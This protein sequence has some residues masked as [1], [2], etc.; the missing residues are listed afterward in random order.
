MFH[1]H[2]SIIANFLSLFQLI[3]C[4]ETRQCDN[5]TRW[6][7]FSGFL[8]ILFVRQSLMRV[9]ATTIGVRKKEGNKIEQ[10][11]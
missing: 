5:E 6:N 11:M 4:S 8:Y 10:H 1:D 7:H 9:H 2:L 3:Q